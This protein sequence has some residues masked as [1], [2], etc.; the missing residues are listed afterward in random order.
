MCL[1]SKYFLLLIVNFRFSRHKDRKFKMRK[2]KING[3]KYRDDK[4]ARG[5]LGQTKA[6]SNLE[7]KK[8]QTNL[9]PFSLRR[10]ILKVIV[11]LV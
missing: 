5:T 10:E 8:R 6:Q 9:D 3:C 2:M 11:L 7:G 4:K 1:H